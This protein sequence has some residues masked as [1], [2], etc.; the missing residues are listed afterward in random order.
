MQALLLTTLIATTL[1][2]ANAIEFNLEN[3]LKE[4]HANP[5]KVMHKIPNKK[6]DSSKKYRL[7]EKFQVRDEITFSTDKSEYR[8]N[9]LPQVLLG[10]GDILF[11]I[12]KMH[13]KDLLKSKPLPDA[14]WSDDY[15]PIYRGILGNR[16]A[17]DDFSNQY[18]WPDAHAYVLKRPLSQI[19]DLN[20]PSELDKLSPSEKYD[21]VMGLGDN[22]LTKRMWA[23][24]KYYFDRSGRVE[25]WMGICHGWAPASYMLDRPTN[26]VTVK[27]MDGREITFYPSDIKALSSLLWA[28]T[29]SNMNFIGG[30]CNSKNPE[31]DEIG[32][33]TE[34]DCND[35]NPATWH[36]SVVN[37]LGIR[38]ESFVF[39]ATFDYEVW[40]QPL[41]QYQY[42]YFN[43]ETKAQ[44]NDIADALIPIEKFSSDKLSKY[45]SN[46]TKFIVGIHMRVTYLVETAPSTRSADNPEYDANNEVDYVYDLELDENYNAIGG[47]WYQS[48]HPDFLWTPQQGAR[49]LSDGDFFILGDDYWSGSEIVPQLWSSV[50]AQ[51]ARF[52]QPL[53]MIVESLIKLSNEKSR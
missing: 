52:G 18:T 36:I 37:K 2:S 8:S 10:G 25:T 9:D 13:E 49:A 6:F 20:D 5:N 31:R 4:F 53:A 38:K 24:G 29:S 3:F 28:K 27:A 45:R 43:P 47:E 21:Y 51:S 12:K 32:R 35:T 22:G 48:A 50:A 41:L 40:N 33:I 42:K 23:E 46:K 19:A 7:F 26:K 34:K 30:R 15:W 14:P 11:N 16:Y 1:N 44:S 39:D 17:D